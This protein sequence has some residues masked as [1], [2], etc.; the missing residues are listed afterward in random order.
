MIERANVILGSS[1]AT[2]RGYRD[3]ATSRL[4]DFAFAPSERKA[5]E[6]KQGRPIRSD[7]H[8]LFVA[9]MEA[10]ADMSRT[11]RT[12]YGRRWLEA[13]QEAATTG[14]MCRRSSYSPSRSRSYVFAATEIGREPNEAM[15]AA[16][17][18]EARLQHG[19]DSAVAIAANA[20]TIIFTFEFLLQVAKR[21]NAEEPSLEMALAPVL[22]FVKSESS[23][24]SRRE[25]PRKKRHPG[26]GARG[27][28]PGERCQ[29]PS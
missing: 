17:A 29:A 7:E 13:A 22:A 20:S 8:E 11:R 15:V 9:A 25:E 19:T 1:A 26:S 10:L 21:E 28:V 18:A 24:A 16:L 27:A 5:H 2:E 23:A 12:E 4:I 3:W 14:E 6:D